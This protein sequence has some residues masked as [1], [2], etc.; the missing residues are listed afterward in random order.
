MYIV[1]VLRNKVL[2]KFKTM[3]PIK[4]HLLLLLITCIYGCQQSHKKILALDDCPVV[5]KKTIINGDTVITCDFSLVKDTIEFPLSSIMSDLEI[6]K[7]ENSDSALVSRYHTF[8]SKNYV[9]VYTMENQYK[10]F[11]K[12]GNLLCYI[13]RKGQGPGEYMFLYDSQIDE[14]NNCIYLMPWMQKKILMY[15]LQGKFLSDIPLPEFV[16]KARF[17]I[18]TDEQIVTIMILPFKGQNNYVVWQQDFQGNVLQT[19]S[20]EHFALEPDY[21]NEIISFRNTPDIDFYLAGWPN[22]QDTLYYYIGNENRLKPVFTF[23]V[24]EPFGHWYIDL[25]NHVITVIAQQEVMDENGQFYAPVPKQFIVDKRTLKGA[26]IKP[27]I[28]ELGGIL[29]PSRA[30][31]QDGYFIANM[32]PHELKAGL[33]KVI[34]NTENNLSEQKLSDIKTLYENMDEEGNNYILI[35]KLKK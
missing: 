30:L 12:E 28:D 24:N 34:S 27:I 1:N 31:Y 8:A 22:K 10:L 9:G 25:P 26:Y 17:N 29:I 32:Y 6:V 7:L 11:D 18:N 3:K 14:K 4:I 13:G 5:A 33:E 19:I 16:P 23:T 2:Q 21:G 20:S 35:G 15:N